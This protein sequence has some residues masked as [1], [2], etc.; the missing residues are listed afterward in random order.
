[1]QASDD[2]PAV[3]SS[4]FPYDAV[5][6]ED[7]FAAWSESIAPLFTPR[8]AADARPEHVSVATE[9]YALGDALFGRSETHGVGGYGC[10]GN[11]VIRDRADAVLVQLYRSGGF[12]GGNGAEALQV[13]AGD[14][15]VLDT[16]RAMSTSVSDSTILSLVL[17][18]EILARH[19]GDPTLTPRVISGQSPAGRVLAHTFRATWDA[20]PRATLREGEGLRGLLLGAI[21]GVLQDQRRS[22]EPDTVLETATFDAI[23]AHIEAQLDDPEL[24]PESLCRR[25]GC[26]R[27]QLYRLFEPSGGVASVIRRARLERAHTELLMLGESV[28][29]PDIARRWGF[30]N[31]SHFGRMFRQ[32]FGITPGE[33]RARGHVARREHRDQPRPPAHVS[34]WMPAYRDWFLRL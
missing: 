11:S 26:S 25:F 10:A 14:V 30:G 5:P 2:A 4:C 7:R 1:M 12:I 20:L 29:I 6:P 16:T 23:R 22:P 15:V 24:S 3:P 8:V 21:G 17:P 18:R 34:P 13:L 31:V 28:A 33:A 27:S 19:A 9:V 32:A